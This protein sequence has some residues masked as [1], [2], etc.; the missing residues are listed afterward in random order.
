MLTTAQSLIIPD[1]KLYLKADSW[2]DCPLKCISPFFVVFQSFPQWMYYLYMCSLSITFGTWEWCA[3]YKETCGNFSAVEIHL[4]ILLSKV[5]IPTSRLTQL[6]VKC[7]PHVRQSRH[8]I[9]RTDG[10][11]QLGYVSREIR[12]FHW[13][14]DV[15]QIRR[16]ALHCILAKVQLC[17]I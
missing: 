12:A 15:Q 14:K 9:S 16:R 3:H 6:P 11:T 10:C 4:K 2:A 5:L 7:W 13:N 8:T 17:Y 1:L